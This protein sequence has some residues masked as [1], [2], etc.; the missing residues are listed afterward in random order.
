M[1]AQPNSENEYEYGT[2]IQFTCPNYKHYFD[3]S[4]PD[5]LVSFYYSTNINTTTLTCNEYKF[6]TVENGING[7]TC[8]NKKEDDTGAKFLKY[9]FFST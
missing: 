2:E 8:A 7:E 3:Y 4:V 9:C 5:N 1:V 6:W